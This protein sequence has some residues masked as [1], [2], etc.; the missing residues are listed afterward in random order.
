MEQEHICQGDVLVGWWAQFWFL[1]ILNLH[2]LH[3]AIMSC[4]KFAD[5]K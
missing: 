2:D 3:S 1:I 5:T 4:T